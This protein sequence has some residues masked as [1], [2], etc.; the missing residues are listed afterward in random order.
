MRVFG[1]LQITKERALVKIATLSFH[2]L[3]HVNLCKPLCCTC[4]R[5]TPGYGL[6]ELIIVT[7][8]LI[9]AHLRIDFM[10]E[11][12]RHPEAMEFAETVPKG[13]MTP[14]CRPALRSFLF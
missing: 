3:A 1:A 4:L 2:T 14:A 7:L 6:P 12:P 5:K 13:L 8:P 10:L 11:F 9:A